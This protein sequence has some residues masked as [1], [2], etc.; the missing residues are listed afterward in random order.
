MNPMSAIHTAHDVAIPVSIPGSPK[1]ILVLGVG[2]ILLGDEGVGVRVVDRLMNEPLPPNV[3]VCD[4]ATAGA[5]LIDLVAGRDKVI[6]IDAAQTGAPPGTIFR[7]T[8]GQVESDASVI[9]SLHEIGVMEAVHMAGILG[10]GPKEVVIF[11]VAP[12]TISPQ[13]QLS[14]EI[15][16]VIPRI[17]DIVKRELF[18]A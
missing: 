6:I 12:K 9:L 3:E 10:D 13:L 16:A 14:P 15:R 8:P 11:A 4:G 2:N 18:P 17:M 7:F 1:P 5:D